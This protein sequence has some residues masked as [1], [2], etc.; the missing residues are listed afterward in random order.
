MKHKDK[1]S[2]PSS[3]GRV[4]GEGLSTKRSEYYKAGRK[5]RKT[6]SESQ[7]HEVKELK[8]QVAQIPEIVQEQVRDQLGATI[9]AIMPSL[10]EGLQDVS[11]GW[12]AG[13]QQGPPP[14][15]SFMGSNSHNAPA[16]VSPTTPPVVAQDP[17]DDDGTF[18]NVDKYINEHG[19][20][21]ELFGPPSQKSNPAKDDGDLAGIAEK[22]NCNRRRLF[23]SQETPPAAAFT[24]TQISEDGPPISKDIE[25]RVHVAGRPML[26]TNLLNA[27]TGAMWIL[28]DLVLYMEKRRL[29]ENDAT[30]PVFVAKVPEGKGFIDSTIGRMIVL[31]FDDIFAMLNLYPLHYTFIRLFSLS[32]DMWIIRDKTPDIVIVDPFYMRAK[33]LGSAGDRQVVSSYLEGVI[34]AN[35]DKDNFLVPYFSDDTH[36]TLILLSPKYSMATYFDSDRQSKKDYTNIKKVLDD[37][38]PGYAKSGGTFRR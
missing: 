18:S 22:H 7:E 1:L 23:S 13:G 12:I 27:A 35:A 36:C 38:L 14:I 11:R 28:H 2:K 33:I 3:A 29:S 26:P 17:D 20:G 24:E 34:L 6:S 9:P 4:A 10:L 19:Y 8:A 16:S 5:E 31:R 32:M 15:P 30:Y 37:V 21:D 25:R